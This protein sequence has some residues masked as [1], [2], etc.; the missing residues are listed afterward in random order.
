MEI[1]NLENDLLPF[2]VTC[3]TGDAAVMHCLEALSHWAE[4]SPPQITWGALRIAGR[5]SARR[6][7]T[8]KFTSAKNRSRFLDKANELLPR[9]WTRVLTNE[10][11]PAER[12]RQPH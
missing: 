4:G 9:R 8:F 3:R 5:V 7:V 2:G 6:E 12:Q 1:E 10:Y 11:D